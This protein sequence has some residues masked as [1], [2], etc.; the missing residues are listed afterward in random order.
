MTLYAQVWAEYRGAVA[1]LDRIHQPLEY[2]VPRVDLRGPNRRRGYKCAGR[3]EIPTVPVAP[4]TVMQ[5][6]ELVR[7]TKDRGS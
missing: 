3:V 4:D 6:V 5:A 1:A 7:Q 2:A